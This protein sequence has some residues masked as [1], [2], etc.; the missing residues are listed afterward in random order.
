MRSGRKLSPHAEEMHPATLTN[1]EG[2]PH[3]ISSWAQTSFG[4]YGHYRPRASV[5]DPTANC[6]FP[7][8]AKSLLIGPL[9]TCTPPSTC[10]PSITPLC[11]CGAENQ[12][13]GAPRARPPLCLHSCPETSQ[14][15]VPL[16]PEAH[17]RG[18]L[19]WQAAA[20]ASKAPCIQA[21][22]GTLPLL[23]CRHKL[24]QPAVHQLLRDPVHTTACLGPAPPQSIPWH[25]LQ[26]VDGL[27]DLKPGSRYVR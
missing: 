18:R 15:T 14:G 9:R 6:S 12:Q 5:M 8:V 3:R 26:G 10:A 24:P 25:I 4:P 21:L 1:W 13:L 20:T 16:P 7:S 2:F 23:C 22:S 11:R 17:P 27:P 19:F